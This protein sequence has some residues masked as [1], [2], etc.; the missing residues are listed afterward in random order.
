MERRTVEAV[1]TA[2]AAAAAVQRS[3]ETP[4]AALASCTLNCDIPGTAEPSN[5]KMESWGRSHRW[6]PDRKSSSWEIAGEKHDYGSLGQK[7][8]FWKELSSNVLRDRSLAVSG[9]LI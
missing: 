8:Q 3:P 4:K 2:A 1:E 5:G 6:S 7:W 9:A